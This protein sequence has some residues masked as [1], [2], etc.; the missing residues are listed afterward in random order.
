M[1]VS[2][3]DKYRYIG[4]GVPANVAIAM[5]MKCTYETVGDILTYTVSGTDGI[6]CAVSI[7]V[8]S[9]GLGR[10]NVAQELI[11]TTF[12]SAAI[13]QPSLSH[14][15]KAIALLLSPDL[16]RV[17][18]LTSDYMPAAE[19]VRVFK[20][21][22]AQIVF[23]EKVVRS[24]TGVAMI[25]VE[26]PRLDVGFTGFI[27]KTW[28]GDTIPATLARTC[29]RIPLLSIVS[30]CLAAAPKHIELAPI[31]DTFVKAIK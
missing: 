19:L 9:S 17:F 8:A 31:V 15:S 22:P 26:V 10:D 21:N 2:T 4:V 25:I 16:S 27:P 29:C 1:S 7:P 18:K 3:K 5:G 6:E 28:V 11:R 12:A 24:V 30:S 14:L 23:G 13:F 20:F